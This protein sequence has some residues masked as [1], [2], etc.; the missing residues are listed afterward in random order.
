MLSAIAH[1]NIQFRNTLC[2]WDVITETS[3]RQNVD[4]WAEIYMRLYEQQ[5]E[6]DLKYLTVYK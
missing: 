2:I 3:V 5:Y 6:P 1:E 4:S